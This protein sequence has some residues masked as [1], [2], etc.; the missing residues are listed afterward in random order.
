MSEVEPG[1]AQFI[2]AVIGNFSNLIREF[3]QGKRAINLEISMT[4]YK[5]VA[6]VF[7]C[8]AFPQ[9][10]ATSQNNLGTAYFDRIRGKKTENL[11]VAISYYKAALQEYTREAFPQEWATIQNGLGNVYV[12]RIEGKRVDNLET[13][14]RYYQAALEIRTPSDS[15]QQWATTQHNLGTA[16][17][18][19]IV[20]REQKIW[21]RQ[22][23]VTMVPWRY[24]SAK[25]P[26]TLQSRDSNKF[27]CC[28]LRA[29]PGKTSRK[30]G[31]GNPLLRCCFGG[32]HRRSFSRKMGN[33]PKQSGYCL[34]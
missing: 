17:R 11:E 1:K 14:I 16:Y 31:I 28:L 19:R 2:A 23:A 18:N 12:K 21:N 30:F 4:G 8:E 29:H 3:P 24:A 6:T 13:G 32:T 25:S 20:G 22:S 10:W 33:T 5:F 26:S 27:G 34:L 15:P 7:T 9:E